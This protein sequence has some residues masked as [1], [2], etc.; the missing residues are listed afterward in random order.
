[1]NR[2]DLNE[3]TPM[4]AADCWEV[5]RWGSEAKRGSSVLRLEEGEQEIYCDEVDEAYGGGFACEIFL[6]GDM[7]GQGFGDS[8]QNAVREA[9]VDWVGPS[10]MR[11]EGNCEDAVNGV[12]FE[13]YRLVFGEMPLCEADPDQMGAL[14]E[15]ARQYVKHNA[16]YYGLEWVEF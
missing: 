10:V 8:F 5:Y 6:D 13:A 15:C 16:R 3:Y 2:L 14:L 9:F 12:A 11:E 7:V 1:M 4:G